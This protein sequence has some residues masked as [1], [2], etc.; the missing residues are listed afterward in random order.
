MWSEHIL[1]PSPHKASNGVASAL[2]LE[3]LGIYFTQFHFI[4]ILAAEHN[5]LIFHKHVDISAVL[6]TKLI[7]IFI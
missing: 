1:L 4:T 2:I 6:N 7:Y 5:M 3:I